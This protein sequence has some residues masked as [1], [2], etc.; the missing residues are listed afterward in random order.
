M[1]EGTLGK[2]AHI[3]YAFHPKENRRRRE[4]AGNVDLGDEDGQ[5]D[6]TAETTGM[7]ELK[8]VSLSRNNRR[9]RRPPDVHLL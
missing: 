7:H 1:Y 2:S 5:G 6:P 9:P 8:Q 3:T 4:V